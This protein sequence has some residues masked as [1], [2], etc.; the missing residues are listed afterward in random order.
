MHE[1]A[2]ARGIIDIV[3]SEAR[4]R[5]FTRVIEISVCAGEFSGVV[6]DS[7]REFFPY[8]A[9]GTPAEGAALSIETARAR[10]ECLDCGYKGAVDRAAARCPECASDALKM[11][12]GREFYVESLKV[13]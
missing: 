6:P 10:F 3:D 4:A 13:E 7:L 8:A 5:G 11:L 1:L 9:A 12:S 2:L